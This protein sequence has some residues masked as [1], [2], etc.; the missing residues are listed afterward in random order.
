MV[1]VFAATAGAIWCKAQPLCQYRLLPL[2]LLL[3]FLSTRRLA[4]NFGFVNFAGKAFN[5][6]S[7]IPDSPYVLLEDALTEHC[8][9]IRSVRSSSPAALATFLFPQPSTPY[10]GRAVPVGQTQESAAGS[11]SIAPVMLIEGEKYACEACVR[12]HR[13]S[14]CQH[15]GKHS[16]FVAASTQSLTVSTDRP[17]TH[18]NKKGRPVSQCPHC[19]GLRKARA[20]HVKCDCG[21]NPHSKEECADAEIQHALNENIFEFT[22]DPH[23]PELHICCCSHGARCTCANKKEYLDPVPEADIPGAV[24]PS[25]LPSRKPRLATAQSDTSLTVFT[26][27]HHKPVHKYNDA[28]HKCGAPYKI[29]IPHSIHGNSDVARRS[30]D[31]LPLTNTLEQPPSQ[32]Q[33]SISSAQQE[34][35]LVRSEHGSPEQRAASTFDGFN[36][37]LPS[38]ALERSCSFIDPIPSP[39]SEDYSSYQS[40]RG[41][42]TYFT[43]QE[44]QPAL[45]A[46]FNMPVV[47]WSALDLPLEG[48][49]LST[50]YSQPPSYASFDHSN[51]GQPGLTTASSDEVS[52]IEEYT[53]YNGQ[54]S[55]MMRRDQNISSS[56]QV[57][58]PNTYRLSSASSFLE[59]PQ[60]SMLSSSS[61]NSLDMDTF[62]QGTTA[63][64]TD[65]E[66]PNASTLMDPEQ[67]VK[68]GITVKDAQKLAHPGNL[69][70]TGPPIEAMGELSIPTP[71]DDMDPLWAAP[72]NDEV[73]F[74]SEDDPTNVWGR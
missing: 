1:V 16:S 70:H 26:N 49:N 3:L 44:D 27:G 7:I 19:R 34:V 9:C 18:I 40:P 63:S 10:R 48:G 64:P 67:F 37:H 55:S 65:V 22:A 54:S 73:S 58:D 59:L 25:T 51:V 68:H 15:S 21:E 61:L 17:L 6:P 57:T 5:V 12:G 62:L 69:G 52:E 29:P 31:H 66:G 2:L 24:A 72:L 8:I 33:E 4:V 32:L 71:K 14:N 60:A 43:A 53:S 39:P 30:V 56:S 42:E 35:R 23:A 47:D 45:S 38:L 41:F 28:A 46:G 13:V 11:Q 36:G 74:S 20:S 50:S